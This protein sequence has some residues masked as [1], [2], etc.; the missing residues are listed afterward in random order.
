M[1]LIGVRPDDLDLATDEVERELAERFFRL[2]V[3]DASAAA[4]PEGPLPPQD[5]IVGAFV[6]DL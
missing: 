3:R 1:R 4:L 5:T 2:R 6:R